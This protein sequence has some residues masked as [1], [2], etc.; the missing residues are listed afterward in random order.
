[1]YVHVRVRSVQFVLR[2]GELMSMNQ[3]Q[4][5]VFRPDVSLE[6]M[7]GMHV[8]IHY[9]G[10]VYLQCSCIQAITLLWRGRTVRSRPALARA[11]DTSPDY[12]GA[13]HP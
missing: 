6:T 2:P 9:P 8:R 11:D 1:M 4:L 12:R 3:R 10:N 7:N 13:D 5:L